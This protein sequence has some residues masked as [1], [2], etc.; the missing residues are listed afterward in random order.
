MRVMIIGL[1]G[2]GKSTL[3]QQISHLYNIPHTD[4]D[5]LIFTFNPE[6]KL[7][8]ERPR[9]QYRKDI[10]VSVKKKDWVIEGVYFLDDISAKA[11]VIFYVKPS[12]PRVLYQQ[13]KRR[14]TDSQRRS[15]YSLWSAFQLTWITLQLV[16]M[17][18]GLSITK[19]L[20]YLSC[21]E[22]DMLSESMDNLV[23]VGSGKQALAILR[24]TYVPA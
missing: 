6:R 23:T 21:K 15:Y 20:R 8:I 2:S 9:S 4:L 10:A 7:K 16:H 13:W 1:P 24:R 18:K 5:Y 11:D 12:L 17:A 14:Y 3:A 19:N 22:M